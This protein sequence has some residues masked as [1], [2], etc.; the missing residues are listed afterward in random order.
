MK[1]S[2]IF[3]AL[4]A[5]LLAFVGSSLVFAQQPDEVSASHLLSS[6]P[7]YVSQSPRGHRTVGFASINNGIPGI[8][9]LVNWNGDFHAN[10]VD[11]NGVPRTLWLYNMIGN[12]PENG[13][14]TRFN[15]PIVPV[16]VVL[17]D[18]NGNVRMVNG[19]PM[20]SS[21]E[22]FVGP[23]ANSPVFKN[24]TY[25]TSNVP[26]QISDAIQRAE[27]YDRMRW[28]WHTLL[29]GAVKKGRMMAIPYGKYYFARNP[30]GTCC[31]FIL[32][33]I[34]EFGNLLFPTTP[35]DT[36]TPVGAAENAGDITTKDLSTFLFPNTYLYF[37]GDPNQCCV[38]GYHSYDFEPGDAQNGNLEKRYVLNYSSWISEG[39]FGG[40]FQDVT[41]TS[42]EIAEIFNDPF[43][44]SDGVHNITPWWLAPN[45]NCQDNLE[46][47]DV[48][49]GLPN[50]VFPVTMNG[51]TYHP[52][53]EALLQWFEFKS[54]SN[55]FAAAYSYP[56]TTTLTQ[57]SPPEKVN[58]Q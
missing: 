8:D 28:D 50:A 17:L 39:L 1:S 46:T 42:H 35:T 11:Q 4:A 18:A 16:T 40:G 47:G 10:G 5:V 57:L 9:S 25:S 55:A 12:P 2:H 44:A 48:V 19:K 21:P 27:F 3:K 13:G 56:D 58:C 22:K 15:A 53:N 38:L 31:Q 6:H 37:N 54:P 52:Q 23:T 29:Q 24:H 43:V 49:E 7:Q 33:D 26:T 51:R 34:N 14:T 30:D 32:V 36:T 20:I 45:G 41:A